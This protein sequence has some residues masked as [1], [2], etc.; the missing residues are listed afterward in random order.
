MIQRIQTV[1]LLVV[2]GLMTALLFGRFATVQLGPATGGTTQEMAADGSMVR[3]TAVANDEIVF[4]LWGIYENGV[5]TVPTLPYMGILVILA[6]A[7]AFVTIFLYRKRMIQL[8]LC[9]VLAILMLGIQGFIV[10]HLYKL[11]QVLDAMQSYA[12]RYTVFDIFPVVALFFVWLAFR[13]VTKD[14]AL[15]KSLDRIR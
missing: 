8:R 2:V 10:M 6:L 15:L 7:V 4:S 11:T 13:G 9:F 12:I 3:T 5:Q 1:W 14:V